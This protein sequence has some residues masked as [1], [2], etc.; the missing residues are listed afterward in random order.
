MSYETEHDIDDKMLKEER[1]WT[2]ARE[3][4]RGNLHW[5]LGLQ[6]RI[7]KRNRMSVLKV[8]HGNV[9]LRQKLEYSNA[10]DSAGDGGCRRSK[11]SRLVLL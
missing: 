4:R 9:I 2:A 8:V 3:G 6:A 11:P 5:S 7:C 10:K 1:G